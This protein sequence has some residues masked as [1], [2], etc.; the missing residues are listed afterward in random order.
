MAAS[1]AYSARATKALHRLATMIVA[2]LFLVF[3]NFL[4]DL[5]FRSNKHSKDEEN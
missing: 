3:K 1:Y 2:K 5:I 4:S